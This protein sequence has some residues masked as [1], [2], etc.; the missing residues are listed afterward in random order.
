MNIG[1]NILNLRK[2][3]GM[4]QETLA[5]KLKVSRQTI[6]N[7]ELNETTP[8]IKQ[9]KELSKIFNVTLDELVNNDIDKI[10]YKRLSNVEKLSKILIRTFFISLIIFIIYFI[11]N[12]CDKLSP[13]FHELSISKKVKKFESFTCVLEGN[14]YNFG[15]SVDQNNKVIGAYGFDRF[16]RPTIIYDENGEYKDSETIKNNTYKFF[17]NLNGKCSE[18][19]E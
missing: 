13:W 14:I 3:N 17:E 8:D 10:M 9:S 5:E 2:N 7:W 19:I 1:E 4:S 18:I 6:S 15:L 16:I 11:I 12:I